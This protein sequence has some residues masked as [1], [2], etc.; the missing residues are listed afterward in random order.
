[1][2][3]VL[4]THARARA[5]NTPQMDKSHNTPTTLR[6]TRLPILCRLHCALPPPGQLV[7]AVQGLL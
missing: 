6:L 3:A 5:H 1:M 7:G 2:S 4:H